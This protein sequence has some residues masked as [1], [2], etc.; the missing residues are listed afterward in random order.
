[1][2]KEQKHYQLHIWP[3]QYTRLTG[4][5]FLLTVTLFKNK[6]KSFIKTLDYG[7]E[8]NMLIFLHKQ[9]FLLSLKRKELLARY[10]C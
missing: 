5:F 2:S 6:K 8:S 9:R 3:A 7:L 1:M 4:L 10:L